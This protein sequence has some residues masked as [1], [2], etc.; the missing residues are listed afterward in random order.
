MLAESQIAG[1]KESSGWIMQL[2]GEIF[3][4]LVCS[5]QVQGLLGV[6]V[7]SRTDSLC[8]LCRE[9]GTKG[10]GQGTGGSAEW[11]VS[12]PD[13]DSTQPT[14]RSAV[15]GARPTASDWEGESE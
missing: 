13:G 6:V 9:A 3:S 1:D 4:E 12:S 5:R 14:S 8:R 15:G 7:I 10:G 11:H 2:C